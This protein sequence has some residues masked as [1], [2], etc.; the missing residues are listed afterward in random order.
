[1]CKAGNG[2][3]IR[4]PPAQ[5]AIVTE[6]RMRRVDVGR[7]TIVAVVG[8]SHDLDRFSCFVCATGKV[9]YAELATK[10]SKIRILPCTFG[11]L[12]IY[13]VRFIIVVFDIDFVR[14]V[15]DCVVIETKYHPTKQIGLQ[16]LLRCSKRFNLLYTYCRLRK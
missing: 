15:A 7:R 6:L 5:S 12:I 9:K 16:M 3:I 8:A 11:F 4:E 13:L 2:S 14:H 1:M 10:M